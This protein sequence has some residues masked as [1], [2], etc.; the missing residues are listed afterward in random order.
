MIRRIILFCLPA[1]CLLG[2]NAPAVEVS[3]TVHPARVVNRID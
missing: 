3:L 2:A 1:A